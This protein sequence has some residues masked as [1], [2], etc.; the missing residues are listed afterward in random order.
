MA[1][2]IPNSALVAVDGEFQCP[3]CGEKQPTRRGIAT[4][5]YNKHDVQG[6][7]AAKAAKR[8]RAMHSLGVTAN[9]TTPA[10]IRRM[11]RLW[12]HGKLS[13]REIA[14]KTGFTTA[15]V[16]KYTQNM[17]AIVPTNKH[18]EPHQNG[19]S[20][21][22][23]PTAIPGIH[24]EDVTY[25]FGRI[26]REL[27]VLGQRLEIPYPVLASGMAEFLRVQARRQVVGMQHRM[28]NVRS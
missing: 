24:Q 11:Q 4:H 25:I 22:A 20:D 18:K 6:S 5:R 3:E 26:E 7:F 9:R 10:D 2:Y 8:P 17:S 21:P 15:T 14:E 13:R 19:N 12:A 27:E 28:S 16:L 1:K 23:S